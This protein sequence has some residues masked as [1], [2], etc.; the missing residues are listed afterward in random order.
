MSKLK[1]DILEETILGLNKEIT[2]AEIK[3]EFDKRFEDEDFSVTKD[4]VRKI[5][6]ELGDKG[7]INVEKEATER[8]VVL[9]VVPK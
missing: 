3:E 1:R 6:K 9:K 4:Y 5:V 2:V 8:Y 7:K